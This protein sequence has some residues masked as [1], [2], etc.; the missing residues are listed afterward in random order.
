[1]PGMPQGI[2]RLSNSP[3]KNLFPPEQ[4]EQIAKDP[5]ARIDP[6]VWSRFTIAQQ[7]A[8]QQLRA[9]LKA[10]QFG[11]AATTGGN[12]R[13]GSGG[14]GTHFAGHDPLQGGPRNLADHPARLLFSPQQWAA[15]SANPETRFDGAAWAAFSNEQ[16]AAIRSLRSD[17]GARPMR[18]IAEVITE[19]KGAAAHARV[20]E[21]WAALPPNRMMVMCFNVENLFDTE[22]DVDRTDEEFTPQ[23]GYTLE[24]FEEHLKNIA[25]V[26]KSVNGGRG[27]D[28]LGLVEVEDKGTLDTLVNTGLAGPGYQTVALEEGRDRRGIDVALISRFPQ[29]PG[30]RPRLVFADGVQGQRG[31]LRVELDVKGQRTVAYVNHW[32]SMADGEQYS[33]DINIK[34]AAALKKD[35]AQ[36]CASGE[37]KVMAIGDF[38]TK[39]YDGIQTA[40]N[41]LGPRQSAEQ[42]Q[43]SDLWDTTHTIAARR[44]DGVQ[45]PLLPAGTHG[46]EFLDRFMVN[47]SA[48]GKSPGLKLDPDSV[49]VVPTPGRYFGRQGRTNPNGVADHRPM[50]AQFALE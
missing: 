45:H 20:K 4:W 27:P 32:K 48:A 42:L 8:I 21:P 28:V 38:N 3:A 17:L 6:Q 37:V 13:L 5:Q 35:I 9:D 15:L 1:M 12:A 33:A 10:D 25:E 34:I 40:M 2:S 36:T 49:V 50:V 46:S 31:I 23:A 22:D 47:G 18:S 24:K 7:N 43:L 16:Q 30:T 19:A 39:F 26:I 11:G 44:A 29:W 41:T 14:G